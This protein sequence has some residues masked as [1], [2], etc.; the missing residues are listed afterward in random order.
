MKGATVY[1]SDNQGAP[2]RDGANHKDITLM[3][4]GGLNVQ[5]RLE[6]GD[7]RSGWIKVVTKAGLG[8][9]SCYNIVL[10]FLLY[11]SS[12]G[13]RYRGT[14]GNIRTV[15]GDIEPA[16]LGVTNAHEHVLIRGGLILLKEPDFRLDDVEKA[17]EEVADFHRFGGQAL[18]DTAPIGIG[19]DPEGLKA[20]AEATGVHIVAAT[21]FHKTKY[22]LDSHWRF[23]YS[24]EEIA[25]LFIAEIEEGIEINSYGGPLIRRSTARAGIIKVAS[26]YQLI[27]RATK[28]AF[29]AAGRAHSQ[30]GAPVLTHTEM[31]T[32]ALEQLRMLESFGVSPDH[33]VLSH[34][35]R[36]P[37]PYIHREVAQTGAFLEYDGPGRVKYAPE[38]ALISLMRN[39]FE[40]NLGGKILLGGDT[41]RRSYWKAYGGGPGIAYTLERFV[42]RLRSEGFAER[43]IQQILVDNPARA[44][45]FAS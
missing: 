16:A 4:N 23:H 30:T 6:N 22:Y 15:M 41:A 26:D 37:D 38:S 39:V 10:I 2:I 8:K 45:A 3:C 24:A 31:G 44:F 20:V 21:G 1:L 33:V 27:D 14:V 7:K 17:K 42:P 12:G 34:M 25:A 32:M 5:C 43:E 40:A 28:L 35:D 29:E 36:N 19:R 18:V 13:S 11:F 9:E